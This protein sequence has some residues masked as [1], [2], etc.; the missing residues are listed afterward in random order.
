MS[1]QE[2]LTSIEA[3]YGGWLVAARAIAEQSMAFYHQAPA[4]VA[5]GAVICLVVLGVAWGLRGVLDRQQARRIICDARADL[6]HGY[7][8]AR[9]F[10][11]PGTLPYLI[12]LTRGSGMKA[13]VRYQ[14]G[15]P[16]VSFGWATYPDHGAD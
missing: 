13:I 15:R 2:F 5:A 10:P 14:A 16:E 4:H 1:W 11:T 3:I 7:R 12:R 8:W 9:V 6:E